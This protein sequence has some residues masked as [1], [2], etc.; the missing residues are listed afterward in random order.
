MKRGRQ[1]GS[2]EERHREGLFS[3]PPLSAAKQQDCDLPG[4]SKYILVSVLGSLHRAPQILVIPQVVRVLG[5][6]FVLLRRLS[7]APGWGW[8]P[9]RPSHDEKLGIFSDPPHPTHLILQR[10]ERG[11]NRVS[12]RS[13]LLEEAPI[14]SQEYGF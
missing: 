11:G 14:D 6:S 2:G 3:S 1:R 10:G 13:C 9:G 8:S 5:A 12:N 7:W 4:S